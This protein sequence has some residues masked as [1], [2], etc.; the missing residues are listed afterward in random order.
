MMTARQRLAHNYSLRFTL[1]RNFLANSFT[2]RTRNPCIARSSHEC[3]RRV[4][5]TS[6]TRAS[7]AWHARTLIGQQTIDGRVD[8]REQ[9]AEDLIDLQVLQLFDLGHV[10]LEVG[11]GVIEL[12]K[13]KLALVPKSCADFVFIRGRRSLDRQLQ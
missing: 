4:S 10:L 3:C 7:I 1:S 8:F 2:G 13:H 11:D 9:R 5:T 12:P 6:M